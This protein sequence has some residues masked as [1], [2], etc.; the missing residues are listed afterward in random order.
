MTVSQAVLITSRTAEIF[1]VSDRVILKLFYPGSDEEATRE[2]QI[3]RLV[4]ATGVRCP[5]VLGW[6]ERDGRAGIMYT[7]LEGRS[8]ARWLGLRRPWRIRAAGHILAQAHAELHT[9]HAPELPSLRERLRDEIQAATVVPART[10]ALAL[11][12]VR[13]L[14]DDDALCHG[15]LTTDNVLLTPQGPVVIDWSEA[16]HGDPAADVARSLI[17]LAVAHKYYL[18]P[19]RRPLAQRT[20]AWLAAA[21]SRHYQRLRP[22]SA[23]RIRYWLLPV[24]V[25]RLG[26]GAP[27]SQQFLLTLIARLAERAPAL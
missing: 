16:T 21:Y 9:F 24:A 17:H 13:T 18:S 25:A 3:A 12:A 5:E 1:P 10:R 4:Q 23:G 19:P 6:M 27:I 7:R 14:P 22:D 8:L 2:A 20:H 15:D 11:R 26:R